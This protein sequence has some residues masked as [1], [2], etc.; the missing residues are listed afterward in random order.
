MVIL[1]SI[2]ILLVI[3]FLLLE[4]ESYLETNKIYK[5]FLEIVRKEYEIPDE[6]TDEEK[7]EVLYELTKDSKLTE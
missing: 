2:I 3:T 7:F 1:I 4:L 6:L 5:E